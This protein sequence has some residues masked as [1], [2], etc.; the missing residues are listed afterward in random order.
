MYGAKNLSARLNRGRDKF[1]Q[2]LTA[3]VGWSL[4]LQYRV[5]ISSIQSALTWLDLEML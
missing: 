3:Y 5:Q 1:S 2:S 4:S